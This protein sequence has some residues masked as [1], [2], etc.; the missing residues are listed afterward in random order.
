VIDQVTPDGDV[1]HP[2]GTGKTL[3]PCYQQVVYFVFTINHL[4]VEAGGGQ[5][6]N[7]LSVTMLFRQAPDQPAV[8]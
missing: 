6:K 5:G 1:I 2:D 7:Q 4:G 3:K 8:E